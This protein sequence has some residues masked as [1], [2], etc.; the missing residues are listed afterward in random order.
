MADQRAVDSFAGKLAV[1][2]GGGSGMGRELVV[3]LA[4]AGCSVA[5]CDV[6]PDSVTETAARAQAGAAGHARVTS[7]A[8][9]VSDEAQVLS[10]RDELLEQHDID[11]VDLVFSNAGIG[12]GES[13]VTS[14]RE[15][16]ERTFAV[17]FW[18]VYYCARAFLPLLIA[19]GDGVLV[20]TSSVNGFWA[21]LGPGAPNQAYCT[22]KF[23]VKGFTES[24]IEDL[25]TNAPQVRVVV[26]MPGHVGTDIIANSLRARGLPDASQLSDAQLEELIPARRRPAG[27]SADDLR[28]LLAQANANFRDQAPLS[29][30]GAA[31]IILDGV[32]SGAWRILVGDDAAVLDALVRAKPEAAY[33][34]AELGRAAPGS[35]ASA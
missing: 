3:Q 29:A 4:A 28:Q 26:V 6:H 33:D 25:R 19:S 16:W 30:A 27:A 17:D 35:G 21:S 13:F 34:Y 14:R 7:H 8:C 24:L 1:V 32:R 22:A 2:T 23:A 9:D 15:D 18:G 12:G 11:H 20:N 5:A 10:F 31:T